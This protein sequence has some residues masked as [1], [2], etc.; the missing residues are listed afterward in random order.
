MKIKHKLKGQ[1]IL[2]L[3]SFLIPV[4]ILIV[5]YILR[6]IYPFGKQCFLRSDMY[7]QY[8]PFLAAFQEKLKTGGD[9]TYSWDIGMGIN[10]TALYAYYLATPINWI[11]I[12]F[13][14][15]HLIELMS[16]FIIFKIGLSGF[17]FSYYLSHHLKNKSPYIA[18][19]SIFYALSS[20]ICAYSW[21]LM[22]LDCIWLFPLVML[23]LE[24]LI[25]EGKSA[26]YCITLGLCILSNYYISIMVCIFCVLYFIVEMIAQ[27][28]FHEWWKKCLRF[29]LY[30]ALA[31]GF[32][33]FLLI[34]EFFALQLTVS[35]DMNFPKNLTRYFSILEMLSRQ[36]M[37]VDPAVFSAHEPN[38]Y[39]GIFIFLLVPLYALNPKV[40]TKEKIGKFVLLFVFYLSFNLNIPNYIWH[41]FHFPNSLPCRQ[42]F[43]Y[44]F[45]ILTMAYEG[46][47][48][49]KR[50]SNKEIYSIFGAVILLFLII[51]Q[52]FSGD[53]YSYSIVYVSILFLSLY[54]IVFGLYRNRTIRSIFC[55][56]LFFSVTVIEAFVNTNKTSVNTTGRTSYVSDNE[57]ISNILEYIEENDTSFFRIEKLKRRTKNDSA[58]HHY[59]GVS[60]FSSTANAGLSK[61]LSNMGC[62]E[63]TN[64]YSYYGSTP[65]TEGMLSVKYLLSNNIIEDTLLREMFVYED[66][67]YLYKNNN[68]LP[69]GFLV[70]NTLEEEWVM[71][72]SNPFYVQNNYAELTTGVSPI[73]SAMDYSTSENSMDIYVEKDQNIYVYITSEGEDFIANYYDENGIELEEMEAATF[74]GVKHKYIMDLGYCKAGTTIT[75]S[76]TGQNSIHAYVYGLNLDNFKRY[77]EIMAN[78]AMEGISYDDTHVKGKVTAQEEMLLFTSIIYEK[79]WTAKVD[80]KEVEVLPFKDAFVSIPI[81]AGTHTIELSYTPYGY[82]IGILISL[83]SLSIFVMICIFKAAKY[84]KKEEK[85]VEMMEEEEEIIQ[86]EE[87]EQEMDETTDPL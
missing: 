11:L 53:K 37:L 34:P 50:A 59:H 35:G 15:K 65:L 87:I 70:P 27:K 14:Q 78:Q 6:G 60:L 47:L 76:A 32:A 67:I 16:I 29:A 58:W 73:F 23:G 20:Y 68:I 30:S 8:A 85:Q 19:I 44:T 57:T 41:G 63:S 28:D 83:L 10:F 72:N 79:G 51:E 31:G 45:L 38:I 77:H 71:D 33:A 43:I 86:Q 13:S 54:G 56:I 2:Y 46:F 69:L 4:C 36:L 18:A 7:H 12:L 52:I 82:S 5:L 61:F 3:L 80:G 1:Y 22:W 62:E 66:S 64:S 81:S 48:H 49:V 42:S 26:L 75:L 17:T 9:L 74:N 55:C 24:R 21:N 40:N 84:R 25:K 39:S